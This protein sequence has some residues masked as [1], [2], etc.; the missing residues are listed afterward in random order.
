MFSIDE[1]SRT[2]VYQQIV[3]GIRKEILLNILPPGSQL[4]SV[5]ELS[6]ELRA[7]P[8]TVQKAYNELLR[9]ELIVSVPGKGNF[10]D[11]NALT[12]LKSRMADSERGAVTESARKLS[13]LGVS[14]E[15]VLDWI[16]AAYQQEGGHTES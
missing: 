3:D 14:V 16:R 8:N 11:A 7:N 12:T 1:Y 9:Q 2:P 5:R 10:V 13:R 4:Y 6:A 15:T